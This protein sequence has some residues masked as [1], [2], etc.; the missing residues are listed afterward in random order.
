MI[1]PK[2]K[3]NYEV[4]KEDLKSVTSSGFFAFGFGRNMLFKKA[5]LR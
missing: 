2:E 5:A 3:V 1:P 4:S